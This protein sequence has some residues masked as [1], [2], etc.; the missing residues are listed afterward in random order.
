M[1]KC[2]CNPP[3]NFDMVVSYTGLNAKLSALNTT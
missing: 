1:D 2:S 3:Q